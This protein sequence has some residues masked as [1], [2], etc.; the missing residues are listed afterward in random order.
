[1]THEMRF[2]IGNSRRRYECYFIKTT[3][4]HEMNQSTTAGTNTAE[5]YYRGKGGANTVGKLDDKIIA[6]LAY[7]ATQNLVEISLKVLNEKMFS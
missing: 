5:D 4:L 7:Y 1:M 2:T 3:K 6:A